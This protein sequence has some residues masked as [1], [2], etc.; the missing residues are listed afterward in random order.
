[1]TF[2]RTTG[3]EVTGKNHIDAV[4]QVQRIGRFAEANLTCQFLIFPKVHYTVVLSN[5]SSA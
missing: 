3:Q 1:M 5:V 4:L 2:Q